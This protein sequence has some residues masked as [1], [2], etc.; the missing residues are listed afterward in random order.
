MSEARAVAPSPEDHHELPSPGWGPASPSHRTARSRWRRMLSAE[1][2]AALPSS[3]AMPKSPRDCIRAARSCSE[4]AAKGRSNCPGVRP[5]LTLVACPECASPAEIT[6]RFVLPS[7]AGPVGHVVLD[8]AAG[9]HFRM[10]SDRL[11]VGVPAMEPTPVSD[12]SLRD[13]RRPSTGTGEDRCG[14]C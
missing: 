12:R 11:A 4:Q 7:T 2:A 3:S 1:H 6:D 5:V 10:A 9:H 13:P 8:C 14:S